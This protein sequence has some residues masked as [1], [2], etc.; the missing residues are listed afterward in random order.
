MGIF[1]CDAALRSAAMSLECFRHGNF[2]ESVKQHSDAGIILQETW[3]LMFFRGY[4]SQGDERYFIEPLSPT[5]R[6]EQEHALFKHDPEAKKTN[7]T[8]GTDDLLW[9]HVALPAISVVVCIPFFF[10]VDW[11]RVS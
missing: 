1:S 11:S 7:V 6:D 3:I 10:Y 9:T 8:C 4:F 5:N 2:L